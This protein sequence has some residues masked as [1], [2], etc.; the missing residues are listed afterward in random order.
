MMNWKVGYIVAFWFAT[1]CI[2]YIVISGVNQMPLFQGRVWCLN[3]WST[4]AAVG[5]WLLAGGLVFAI[6]QLQQM[7]KHTNAQIAI[8]LFRDLQ[9]QER[10]DTLTFIYSFNEPLTHEHVERLDEK[11]RYEVG[12]VLNQL[13]TFGVLIRNSVMDEYLAI[14]GYAGAT[15]LRCWYQLHKY[16]R[17]EQNGKRGANAYEHLEHLACRTLEYAKK[18]KKPAYWIAFKPGSKERRLDLVKVL[19]ETKDQKLKPKCLKKRTWWAT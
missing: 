9:S 14:D 17:G 10:I 2:L 5:T 1:G 18:Q 4:V 8:G 15:V 7:R 6:M 11:E 13:D 12:M 16:I 19:T 3:T